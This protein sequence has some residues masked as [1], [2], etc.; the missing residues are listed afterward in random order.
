LPVGTFGCHGPLHR[1]LGFVLRIVLGTHEPDSNR[2]IWTSAWQFRPYD[3]G[4]NT[5]LTRI[6]EARSSSR[7]CR[8]TGATIAAPDFG[9]T[10]FYERSSLSGP[11][12]EFGG[13]A[14]CDAVGLGLIQTDL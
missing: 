7:I 9:F 2:T 3:C 1:R 8:T 4:V 5:L 12:V 13:D 6:C 11:V 10:S 14:G